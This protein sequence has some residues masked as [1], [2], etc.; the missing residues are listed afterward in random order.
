M[1]WPNTAGE[2]LGV[3][4]MWA[5]NVEKREISMDFANFLTKY[6]KGKFGSA[7]FKGAKALEN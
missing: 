6:S 3:P 2:N 1:F 7:S 5:L 4:H